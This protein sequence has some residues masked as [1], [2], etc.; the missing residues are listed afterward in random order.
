MQPL[1]N[2]V[3]HNS[4]FPF[5]AALVRRCVLS[6]NHYHQTLHLKQKNHHLFYCGYLC[7]RHWH[8]LHCRQ[9]NLPFPKANIL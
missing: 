4:P 8:V 3:V 1:P 6:L 9:Q 2:F 5:E 7:G